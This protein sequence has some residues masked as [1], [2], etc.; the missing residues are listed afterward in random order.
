VRAKGPDY[1]GGLPGKFIKLR[2]LILKLSYLLLRLFQPL[3]G[4]QASFA[5]RFQHASSLAADVTAMSG[6][7]ISSKRTHFIETPMTDLRAEFEGISRK[8]ALIPIVFYGASRHSHVLTHTSLLVLRL[9]LSAPASAKTGM[10]EFI[11][12]NEFLQ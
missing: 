3:L 2:D 10:P 6:C 1:S 12:L 9:L 4:R 7:A 8:K 11:Q 5:S